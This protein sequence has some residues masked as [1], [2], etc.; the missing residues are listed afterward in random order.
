MTA[1]GERVLACAVLASIVLCATRSHASVP[2]W[3]SKDGNVSLDLGVVMALEFV[4]YVGDDADPYNFDPL[5]SEGFVLGALAARVTGRLPYHL[6]Y[7]LELGVH[8]GHLTAH[9]AEVSFTP[10]D[11]LKIKMGKILNPTFQNLRIEDEGLGIPFRAIIVRMTQPRQVT[12]LALYGTMLNV[13][14][15]WLGYYP[16]D[17]SFRDRTFGASVAVHPLGPVADRE[18]GFY[19]GEKGYEGFRFSIGA[20]VLATYYE[21]IEDTYRRWGFDLVMHYRMVS[22]VGGWFRYRSNTQALS[23]GNVTYETNINQGFYVQA[24]GFVVP[25]HLC[26]VCRYER[27]DLDAPMTDWAAREEDVITCSAA[28]HLGN[29]LVTVWAGYSHRRDDLHLDNDHA[30]AALQ[31]VL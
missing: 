13:V 27:D 1:S 24:S 15:Y 12:G 19:P 3:Q 25:G 22:V 21:G 31:V 6:N 9:E 20:G 4:P 10:F 30:F 18:T 7:G 5:F 23:C 16:T 28:L 11:F 8:G 26:L 17:T 14:S 2:V 29:G